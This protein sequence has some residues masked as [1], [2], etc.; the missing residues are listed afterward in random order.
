MVIDALRQYR[1]RSAADLLPHG[2]CQSLIVEVPDGKLVLDHCLRLT[3]L[4]SSLE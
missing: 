4:E 1:R 3:S 2:A